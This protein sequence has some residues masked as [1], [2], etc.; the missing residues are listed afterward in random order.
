[1]CCVAF[2]THALYNGTFKTYDKQP[3]Q[4]CLVPKGRAAPY[5]DWTS[6]FFSYEVI[7]CVTSSRR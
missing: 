4:T 3:L 7:Q 5:D 1:M 6:V 2:N